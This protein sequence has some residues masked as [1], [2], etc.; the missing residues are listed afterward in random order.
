MIVL[1]QPCG[2]VGQGEKFTIRTPRILS[3]GQ[4][5]PA[6]S[7][8]LEFSF[9]LVASNVPPLVEAMPT[10][11]CIYTKAAS[12][13]AALVGLQTSIVPVPMCDFVLVD[14]RSPENSLRGRHRRLR[15]DERGPPASAVVTD[16]DRRSLPRT[17]P[18]H[19]PDRAVPRCCPT[20]RDTTAP[21]QGFV[22]WP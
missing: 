17:A 14:T 12:P 1:L 18:T 5:L 6:A 20:G 19:P 16:P 15:L 3:P 9:D 8:S 4:P 13:K 7:I 2:T 21:V 11:L 10:K 22:Q